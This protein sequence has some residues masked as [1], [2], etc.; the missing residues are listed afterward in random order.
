MSSR[1]IAIRYDGPDEKPF[2]IYWSETDQLASNRR[3][4]QVEEAE[5]LARALMTEWNVDHEIEHPD[6]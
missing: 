1:K 3:F 6:S 5:A 4:A 2:R